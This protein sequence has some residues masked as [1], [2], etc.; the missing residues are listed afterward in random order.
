MALGQDKALEKPQL[1]LP[2]LETFQQIRIFQFV[3]DD[4]RHFLSLLW[5]CY[6]LSRNPTWQVLGVLCLYSL[7]QWMQLNHVEI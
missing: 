7:N 5:Y 2:K 3:L 6:V 1:H 4:F